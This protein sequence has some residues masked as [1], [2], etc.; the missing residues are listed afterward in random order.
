MECPIAYLV[1]VLAL[2][3]HTKWV[4]GSSIYP[5]QC[6]P[7]GASVSQCQSYLYSSNNPSSINDIATLYNVSLANLRPASQGNNY[8][9]SVKCS[10]QKLDDFTSA[11]L[12]NTKYQV[13]SGD[14]FANISSTHFNS[15]AWTNGDQN[16]DIPPNTLVEINLVCG[17]VREAEAYIVT[18]TVRPDDTLYKI[19][20]DL[21]SD[22]AE[23]ERLNSRL[24]KDRNSIEGGWVLFVPVGSSSNPG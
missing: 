17:C 24:I 15:Q 4:I 14:T 16:M 10:C 5:F 3:L 21:S 7:K 19:A 12:A 23:I 11:F 2:S 20:E 6:N 13:Q 9:I 22:M 1:L 18:Y 8:L